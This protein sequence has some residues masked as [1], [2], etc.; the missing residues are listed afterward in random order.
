MPRISTWPGRDVKKLKG[1]V[2]QRSASAIPHDSFYDLQNVDWQGVLLKDRPGQAKV[3][4]AGA[5]AAKVD[6][7]VDARDI[8]VP[9]VGASIF[10]S[11]FPGA[12]SSCTPAG[13]ER[14]YIIGGGDAVN[15]AVPYYYDGATLAVLGTPADGETHVIMAVPGST[16][17]VVGTSPFTGAPAFAELRKLSPST[18]GTSAFL[19]PLGDPVTRIDAIVYVTAAEEGGTDKLLISGRGIQ[20]GSKPGVISWDGTTVTLERV[21]D[22]TPGTNGATFVGLFKHPSTGRV[23][24]TM[25]D[26]SA[27][28]DFGLFERS[29]GGG[30]YTRIPIDNV[31]GEIDSGTYGGI[32]IRGLIISANSLDGHVYIFGRG[33]A[34]PNAIIGVY[35]GLTDATKVQIGRDLGAIS[36]P[37]AVHCAEEFNGFVYFGYGDDAGGARLAKVAWNGGIPNTPT[38]TNVEFDFT[39]NFGADAIDSCVSLRVWNGSLYAL[40]LDSAAPNRAFLYKSSGTNTASWTRLGELTNAGVGGY[41]LETSVSRHMQVA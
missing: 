22:N 18:G 28:T 1:V 33:T 24:A 35:P 30:T 23:F 2:R 11:F 14:L 41:G 32:N 31:A 37:K 12:L 34:T 20:A 8:G 15:E 21:T 40:C 4:S 9:V 5:M 26:W 36:G 17:L 3:N 38:W 6:F 13:S 10:P 27:S 39:A 25:Y 29:P 16:C 7:M 19:T